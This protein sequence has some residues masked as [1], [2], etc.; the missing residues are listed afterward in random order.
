M[1]IGIGTGADGRVSAALP[2]WHSRSS[3]SVEVRTTYEK[4]VPSIRR[5]EIGAVTIE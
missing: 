1:P 2:S 4:Q 5:L 3:K